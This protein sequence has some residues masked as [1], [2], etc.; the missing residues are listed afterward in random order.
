MNEAIPLESYEIGTKGL[1][2]LRGLVGFPSQRR[3]AGEL[4]SSIE[5]INSF[6]DR[7]LLRSITAKTKEEFIS[8]RKEVFA[9]YVGVVTSLAQLVRIM[10]PPEVTERIVGEAFCELEADFQDEGLAR[11]GPA[12]KDQAMFTI[13]TLR[14]TSRLI[15]KISSLGAPSPELK[16]ED[17]KVASDFR[18]YAT[19]TQ[20]HLDCMLVAIRNNKSIQLEVLPE[21]I[22]GLRAA[23]NAYGLA[24]RGLNLRSPEDNVQIQPY[25]WDEEDQDLLDSSMADMA[26]EVL[27]D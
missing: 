26:L 13:W 5:R 23:V 8:I 27:D 19:W 4:Y 14:R 20:F 22:E 6:I 21:V 17:E 24:K 25:Q 16:D 12:A 10:V 1:N 9:P 7:L 18:F 15:S 11:F 2:D 3:S